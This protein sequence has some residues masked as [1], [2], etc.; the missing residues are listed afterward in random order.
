MRSQLQPTLKRSARRPGSRAKARRRMPR[1]GDDEP[2]KNHPKRRRSEL[3]RRGSAAGRPSGDAARGT[4]AFAEARRP[5][6]LVNT[7]GRPASRPTAS[8]DPGNPSWSSIASG[9]MFRP[10][11]AATKS[12]SVG[13]KT[14]CISRS[15][16][17][18]RGPPGPQSV[19]L[20]G[21]RRPRRGCAL[22][23]AALGYPM[24][25][26]GQ[27]INSRRTL[28]QRGGANPLAD[29][30]LPKII[31]GC[32]CRV[33]IFSPVAK[34][35]IEAAMCSISTEAST[36]ALVGALA[37]EAPRLLSPRRRHHLPDDLLHGL[38]GASTARRRPNRARPVRIAVASP[39]KRS[40]GPVRRAGRRFSRR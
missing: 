19:R 5:S 31:A 11:R 7:P 12:A 26:V 1:P 39:G 8:T 33:W 16:T 18:L 14:C 2:S 22:A 34:R 36:L 4:T 29:Q 27:K 15:G 35:R 23:S 37:A 24:P 9:A 13:P 40:G 17:C 10:L 21:G 30:G 32:K 6:E 28:F 25:G 38:V 3:R 20:A